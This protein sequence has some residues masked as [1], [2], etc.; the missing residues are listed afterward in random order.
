MVP[1]MLRHLTYFFSQKMEELVENQLKWD[2]QKCLKLLL[3]FFFYYIALLCYDDTSAVFYYWKYLF[4]FIHFNTYEFDLCWSSTISK[5]FY[6]ILIKKNKKYL[7]YSLT[8][9]WSGLKAWGSRAVLIWTIA[10]TMFK[11]HPVCHIN[12][13]SICIFAPIF[14]SFIFIYFP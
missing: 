4:H 13:Y 10:S 2:S 11:A 1:K 3:W 9:M 7:F 6:S 12:P 5:C 8:L 14:Q